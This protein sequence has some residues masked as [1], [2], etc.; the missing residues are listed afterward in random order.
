MSWWR[1]ENPRAS[2]IVSVLLPEL[3]TSI[4]AIRH[5]WKHAQLIRRI[6]QAYVFLLI[7]GSLQPKRL[8][9]LVG[10]HR[11]IHWLAFASGTFLLFLLA[12]NLRQAA[13]GAVVAFALGFSLEW[14]QHLI[15]HTAIE[16]LD[17]IDDGGA[18]LVTFAVYWF[19]IRSTATKSVQS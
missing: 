3:M 17:L 2:R 18:I 4:K 9:S 16:W 6:T 11:Q 5:V 12:R 19:A 1:P 8:P 15:Y 14:V 10:L 13:Q 7:L